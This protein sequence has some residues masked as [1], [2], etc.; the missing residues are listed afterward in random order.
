MD[1]ESS[2]TSMGYRLGLLTVARSVLD[3]RHLVGV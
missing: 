2:H 3:S 1:L